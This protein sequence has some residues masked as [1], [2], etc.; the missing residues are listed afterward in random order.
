MKCSTYDKELYAVVQ[1]LRHWEHNL[2]GVEFI[3]YSD[4][5]A[6][7]FL[8][9]QR[10]L[11]SRHAGRVSY[12]EKFSFVLQHKSGVSNKVADVLSWKHSLLTTLSCKIMGFDLLPEYYASD[13]TFAK[14]LQDLDDARGIDY[15][16]M[17]GYLFRGN[18]LCL[19]EGSLRLLVIEEL[20][21]GGIGRHFGRG[22]GISGQR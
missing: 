15:M 2:I 16:L 21:S 12:L 17:N 4:H 20:H 5:A 22:K 1:A 13:S 10:K 11:N 19:P 14:V 7:R 9:G 18:Q 8:K 6:L 3:F